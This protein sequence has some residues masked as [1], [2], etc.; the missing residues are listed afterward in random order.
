MKEPND[1]VVSIVR[2]IAALVVGALV[3]AALRLGVEID[4]QAALTIVMPI[5]Q[6]VVYIVVR[7]LEARVNPV[8]GRIFIIAKPP[9]Y[10]PPR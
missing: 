1:L 7:W 4:Q 5:V 10:T 2:T 6:A 9:T 8:F 3:T